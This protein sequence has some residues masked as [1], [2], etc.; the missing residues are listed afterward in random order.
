MCGSGGADA[1]PGQLMHPCSS[2]S[3]KQAQQS[4]HKSQC[5]TCFH[6]AVTNCSVQLIIFWAE[7]KEFVKHLIV[8]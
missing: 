6:A 8:K 7:Q 4:L 5:H 1:F 3:S 2:Q